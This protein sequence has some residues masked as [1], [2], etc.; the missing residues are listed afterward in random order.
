MDRTSNEPLSQRWYES[1]NRWVDADSA[2]SLMEESKSSIFSQMAM[3]QEGSSVAAKEL[4]A[5]A[6][7]DW[8]TYISKM[9]AARRT[10]NKLKIE[11]EYLKM[12]YFEAAGQA[13]TERVMARL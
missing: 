12:Q 3:R 1:A 7:T 10:A 2:A 6:S 8:E 13:A 9:V 4:K 5:R 11:T